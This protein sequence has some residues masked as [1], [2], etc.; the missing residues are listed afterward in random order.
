MVALWIAA[1]LLLGV[2]V[3]FVAWAMVNR[4]RRLRAAL[5][6]GGAF[7]AAVGLAFVIYA[8]IAFCEAPPGSAC[9]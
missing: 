9:A 1:A 3:A 2:A 8:M 6:L 4:Q 7:I 5:G